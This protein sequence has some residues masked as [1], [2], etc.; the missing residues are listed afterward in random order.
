MITYT[1]ECINFRYPCRYIKHKGIYNF[2]VIACL[3]IPQNIMEVMGFI[4]VLVNCALIG[5][6]G[7]VHRLLPDMTA[8]QTVLL[9]VALEVSHHY[10]CS[11]IFFSQLFPVDHLG[12]KSPNMTWF[13]PS[14][15]HTNSNITLNLV[16]NHLLLVF[17]LHPLTRFLSHLISY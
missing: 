15:T 3:L 13:L 14:S 6:S 10:K 8:I 12:S 17:L 2:G 1:S 9:I 4:A 16:Y 11:T 7:Q 5:L